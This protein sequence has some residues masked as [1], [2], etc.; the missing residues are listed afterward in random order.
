MILQTT[1]SVNSAPIEGVGITLSVT[2]NSGSFN[3]TPPA[4]TGVT[5]TDGKVSITFQLDKAGG[6]TIKAATDSIVNAGGTT[7]SYP[8]VTAA[9]NLFHL[10]QLH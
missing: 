8:P 4:P 5:D 3:L 10:K 6:Y 2:G 9:S 7:H 1:A